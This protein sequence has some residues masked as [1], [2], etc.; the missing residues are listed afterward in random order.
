MGKLK[1]HSSL[2][3][4]SLGIFIIFSGACAKQEEERFSEEEE[5]IETESSEERIEKGFSHVQMEEGEVV[6]RVEGDAVSG[7]SGD[8]IAIENPRMLRFFPDDEES[9]I[10][11]EA[12]TGIWNKATGHVRMEEEVTGE[13]N[14]GSATIIEHADIIDYDPVKHLLQLKGAVKIRQQHSILNAE[15]ILIYLS[16]DESQVIKI[17]ARGKVSG[18]IF[19]EQLKKDN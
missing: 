13:V 18:R 15:E 7:L 6:V 12:R 19:P 17:L 2:W 9:S 16:D 11:I 1:W 8:E 5:S 3:I 10:K 4:L 14:L